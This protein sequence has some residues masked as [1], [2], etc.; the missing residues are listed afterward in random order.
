[1]EQEIMLDLQ[2]II[3]RFYV[4]KP[5]EL[6]ILHGV[7][8]KIKRGEFV[9]IVGASGSG[10]S[11]LMNIIGA[12]DRPT[13]G[14]YHLD[15]IDIC[16]AKDKELS[17]IRNQKIGFIFQTYNLVARTNA[18]QNVELPMLYGRKG[19]TDRNKR[20]KELLELVG[21]ED[22]MN[23]KSDEL[24][25]G[26][27]QRVAIA[28]AL[29]TSPEMLLCDEP[30]SALDPLTTK[31][32]LALL[33]DINRKLGVTI[34]IITHELAVVQAIC[35]RVAVISDGRVAEIGEVAQVFTSPR[36]AETKRLLG[37]EG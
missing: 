5:N 3:K 37:R 21:M 18:L 16:K 35:S 29:A 4:G 22:R 17:R 1:M 34:L 13:E 33:Q 23:H 30:T 19:R 7:N 6:E 26:Q 27:K 32:M 10:K 12:L 24:S 9:S 15:G 2:N 20:A 11:T 8:L 31:A 14:E 28:R 25:G 36:S